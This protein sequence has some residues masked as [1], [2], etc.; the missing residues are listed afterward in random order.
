MA[1][2]DWEKPFSLMEKMTGKIQS[3]VH[4]VLALA[5]GLG[6]ALII[7]FSLA[8]A[9]LIRYVARKFLGLRQA[10]CTV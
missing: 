2:E 3:E 4:N 7:V 10:Q 9:V 8:V 5:F 6:L 1:P